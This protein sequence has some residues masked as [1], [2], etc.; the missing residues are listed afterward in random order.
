MPM[1][2][3]NN[4][5]KR[6]INMSLYVFI[7]VFVILIIVLMVVTTSTI[8]ENQNKLYEKIDELIKQLK[9]NKEK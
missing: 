1:N 2:Y 8:L 3:V 7:F 4:S 5:K 9:E 6:R